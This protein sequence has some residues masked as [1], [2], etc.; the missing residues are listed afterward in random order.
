MKTQKNSV[1]AWKGRT[2]K[3]KRTL[4][5]N[6]ALLKALRLESLQAAEEANEWLARRGFDFDYHTHVATTE[7]GK[8]AVMCFDEGYVLEAGG[9]VPVQQQP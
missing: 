2:W 7:E 5:R 4:D 6:R 9:V 3:V 1:F 8:L